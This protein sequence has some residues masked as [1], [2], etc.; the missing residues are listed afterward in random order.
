MSD[1]SA[2]EVSF[3]SVL[4]FYKK[5]NL[6]S[7][8]GPGSSLRSTYALRKALPK[9]IQEF[10]IKSILDAP[11]GDCYWISKVNLRQQMY[12]GVDIVTKLVSDN[13]QQFA[14]RQYQFAQLDICA[15]KLPRA[16]LVICR[17]FLIHLPFDLASDAI[18]NLLKA[19]KKFI[20]LS[21]YDAVPL[22]LEIRLPGLYRPINL[23]K[24]PFGFPAP[25]LDVFESHD[26]NLGKK[27]GLWRVQDLQKKLRI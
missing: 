14:D 16:D 3:C 1:V 15:D 2:L 19:A 17:D 9:L 26:K 21:S 11:C 6:Q 25:I 5:K 7:L 27:I 10:G 24:P 8:S 22:N 20:L 18:V 4:N 23:N 13:R 12:I